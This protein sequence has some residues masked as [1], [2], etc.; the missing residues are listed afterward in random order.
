MTR[1]QRGTPLPL[2]DSELLRRVNTRAVC[3][4]RVGREIGFHEGVPRQV[5]QTRGHIIRL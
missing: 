4:T 2:K 1:R 5:A 3:R